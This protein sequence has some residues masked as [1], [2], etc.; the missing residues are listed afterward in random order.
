MKKKQSGGGPGVLLRNRTLGWVHFKKGSG[1]ASLRRGHLRKDREEVG[2]EHSRQR[3]KQVQ[4]PQDRNCPGAVR[5]PVWLGQGKQ[6]GDEDERGQ[7]GLVG[8][9]ETLAVTLVRL[10]ALEV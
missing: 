10:P 3:G 6:G 1:K 7:S 2:R 8:Q 4:R 9:G 5:G